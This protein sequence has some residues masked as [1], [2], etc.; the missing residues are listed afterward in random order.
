MN[1][2]QIILTIAFLMVCI[3]CENRRSD[4]QITI[5]PEVV[6][7]GFIGNGAE[8]DP[9][10]EAEAWGSTISDEDWNKLFS[11]LD[12]MKPQYIRCMINS[13]Y[14][15]YN[16]ET[17]KYD[18]NRNIESISRLLKYCTEHDITVIYGEYNPPTWDMKQDQEWIDMSVDYLNYLVTDLGF[19][20][21]KHFVI[22]NEPDGNW[23]STNGDY[24]L[25]KNVLFRFHEKMKTYPGLL[26]KVSF[27]GPDVVVNY[28]NPVSPYDAEGWVKQTVSDVDSLIGIYD[29]HA[30]PGQG[31]VRAGEYKEILAKYKRHIPKGKKI[32]L[33]EAGYKYWNPADS[34][35]GAEYRHRVEN[36]PFTKGSD[37]NLS[38]I[39]I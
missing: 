13:P 32:L 24:E 11:R 20:C 22:F 35:L 18:K 34:I 28:K 19:S 31:Q 23:A 9:Y 4:V 5:L 7:T 14:R 10:D 12:Y 30:Y 36:H 17:G 6:S 29:I 3:A 27:A 38:L 1:I 37:C 25:W 39:H 8:W 2:R 15:Y 26:E 33:G 16:V 21:I